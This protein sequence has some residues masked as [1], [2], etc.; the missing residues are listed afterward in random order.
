MKVLIGER[1]RPLL[2]EILIYQGFEPV[3]LPDNP[4]FNLPLRG[5][6][7]LSVL[8][9]DNCI[10]VSKGTDSKIVNYL[11]SEGCQVSLAQGA[12]G[13]CY[14]MDVG[15]CLCDTGRYVI[16]NPDTA[17]PA[18]IEL[19]ADRTWIPVK[20]GYARCSVCVV[21]EESILTSDKGISSAARRA[22]LDVLEIENGNIELPGYK[23]GFIGG[24]T[25]P[26]PD[27]EIL[28]I[29]SL[30]EHPD[31]DRILSF[32]HEKDKDARF[33]IK[34]PLLDIGSGLILP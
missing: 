34:G 5:H 30:D 25:I 8:P 7:D 24:A 27:K 21:N 33:L 4:L 11:T 1:Y 23:E 14:P 29:G 2:E 12:E 6:T 22:G 26:L 16:A 10:L 3:F 18:A 28:F 15:L 19:L 13:E 17:D 20:Q 32:L 9:K 31:K